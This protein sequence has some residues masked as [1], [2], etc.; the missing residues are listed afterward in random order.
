MFRHFS[1]DPAPSEIMRE[2]A[3]KVFEWVARMWN[4]GPETLEDELISTPDGPP[5][6]FLTE[7][8]ETHLSQLRHNAEARTLNKDRYA[9]RIQGALYGRVPSS[10]YRVWCLENLRE[11]WAQLS[12]DAQAALRTHIIS[13][14]ADILWKGVDFA[15]SDYDQSR[16]APFNRAINVFPGGVPKRR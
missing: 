4:L 9:Q 6:A 7:I 15:L 8:S 10:R 13:D 5:R 2:K 11:V 3:P 1:Q 14:E 12:P 16:K